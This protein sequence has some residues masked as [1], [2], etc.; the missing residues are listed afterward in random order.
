MP[1]TSSGVHALYSRTHHG[2]RGRSA[3]HGYHTSHRADRAQLSPSPHTGE[4]PSFSPPLPALGAGKMFQPDGD[5]ADVDPEVAN[6]IK[7]EKAR[8]VRN[9]TVPHPRCMR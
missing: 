3:P 9:H 1:I 2:S 7:N 4:T 6:I 8:Q 5:L